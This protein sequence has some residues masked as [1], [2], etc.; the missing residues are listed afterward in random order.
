MNS[1]RDS[2]R[3]NLIGLSRR[4]AVGLF[5]DVWPAWA[6]GSLI[7]AGLVALTCRLFIPGAASSLPWLWLSPALATV[8]VLFICYK[9]A[10]RPSEVAALADVLSGGHGVV[11]TRAE[12]ND[13][14][15]SQSSQFERSSRFV[16][17]RL[18]PWRRL[19][20]VV[21]A[22]AFLAV[23]LLLPQRVPAAT[24]AALA[25]DIAADLQGTL[26]ELKQ[27]DLITPEEEKQLEEEIER[28][29][30]DA[31]E[32]VDAASW[33]AVD[34]LRENVAASLA[35]KQDVV[36]WAKESLERYAAAAQGGASPDGS[37]EAAG[38]ELL[39]ALEKLA[40]SGLLAQ[41]PPELLATLRQAKR[42][43]DGKTMQQ[44]VGLVSRYLE[45]SG[46]R[47]GDVAALGRGFGRF[48]PAE[49]PLGSEG[50]DPGG[51]PG[52]GGITRGRADADLTWG[53]ETAPFDRFKS[54]P[55]PPGAAR[56]PDDWAPVVELPGVPRES[57]ARSVG[58]TGRQY[59]AAAGQA[60]W[61]RNLAPRHQRAVKKYFDK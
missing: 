18:R 58:S 1:M 37:A 9:R 42:A 7:G 54:Q 34:T 23:A 41:A 50:G 28:I 48:D 21:P 56:S 33:E 8:P 2:V 39:K 40:Q 12:T 44:L 55:L 6:V 29:R 46:R 11:L 43:G 15:W 24:S 45:Q 13:P 26:A 59:A 22:T 14:A 47:L 30:Q 52:R 36:E 27:Q 61:R 53:K 19:A 5:L 32:R 3:P 16:L 49:F 4:L 35:D 20:A 10:Y 60:A 31:Q 25:D 51:N 57:A 38:A 17:P